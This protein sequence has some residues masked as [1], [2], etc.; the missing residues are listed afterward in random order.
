MQMIKLEEKSKV[1]RALGEPNRLRIIEYLLKKGKCT[2]VCELSR[3]LKRDQSVVF[4]HIQILKDAGIVSTDKKAQFL[5][6]C[7]KD[8]AKVKQYLED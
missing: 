7:I 6:C 2:C 5:A 3:L 8:R 4:R 1:F